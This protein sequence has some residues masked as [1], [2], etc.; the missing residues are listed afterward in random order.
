MLISF[1]LSLIAC[2]IPQNDSD[3]SPYQNGDI[4]FQIS[5]SS[6]APAVALASGSPITHVGLIAVNKTKVTVVEAVEPVREIPIED[7]INHGTAWG[8]YRLEQSPSHPG[9]DKKVISVARSM[10]GKHYDSLFQWSN[11][12][13]YC[14]ELVWKAYKSGAGVEL[15]T[16]EK[17]GDLNLSYEP[18]Q[19]LIKRR[20]GKK[21]LDL[22]ETI[23]TPG[24]LYESDL[25]IHVAGIL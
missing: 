5:T 9:W 13:I 20:L 6:Q 12:K 15:S 3:V 24:A 14:S 1:I 7:F 11:A 19:K 8:V 18:V 22:N 25:I 17:I 23:V 10:K 4:I 2:D 21:K 16:P